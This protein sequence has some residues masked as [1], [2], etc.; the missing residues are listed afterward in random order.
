MCQLYDV[1]IWV[2]LN[3]QLGHMLLSKDN[4]LRAPGLTCLDCDMHGTGHCTW[5]YEIAG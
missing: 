2:F 4:E 5:L 1:T 3:I